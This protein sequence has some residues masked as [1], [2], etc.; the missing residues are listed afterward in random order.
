MFSVDRPFEPGF[1]MPHDNRPIGVFD[2]GLG[3]LTVLRA[4]RARLPRESM[5]YL[6]DTAR[7][8]YGTK[9]EETVQRYARQAA[10][11]LISQLRRAW[12]RHDQ[13]VLPIPEADLPPEMEPSLS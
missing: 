2:S 3:G 4:L 12:F 13:R 10:G 5:L 1:V 8:P 6:G 9:S 7:L 11:A